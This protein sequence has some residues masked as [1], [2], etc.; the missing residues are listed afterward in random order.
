[1]LSVIAP[2]RH[3][4]RLAAIAGLALAGAAP[5][6]RE[7]YR[8][9]GTVHVVSTALDRDTELHAD[10]VV[11]PGP[12]RRDVVLHLASMGY[13]CRVVATRDSAGTLAFPPGQE[14]VLE[15]SSPEARGRVQVRL[16]SGRGRL[17]EEDLSVAFTSELS[18]AVTVGSAPPLLVLRPKVPG[19]GGVQIAVRGEAR[20]IADG[21]RDHSRAAEQ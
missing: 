2:I 6:R 19:T 21:R 1:M 7:I 8:L 16:T 14:C 13:H 10:A 17:R 15:I 18:G 4:V 5:S 12:G 20:V 3:W 11:Q 9:H